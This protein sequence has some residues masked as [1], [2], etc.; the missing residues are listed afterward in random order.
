[1]TPWQEDQQGRGR[2]S[3]CFPRGDETALDVFS[4]G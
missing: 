4:Q 3:W 2:R 1:V